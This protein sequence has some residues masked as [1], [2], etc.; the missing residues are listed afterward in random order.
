VLQSA[1]VVLYDRLV[2]AEV[3]AVANP[4]AN[5][6]YTG[7]HEGEQ[8]ATQEWVSN[9]MLEQARSGKTV[10]RLKGGDPFVFGRGGEEALFLS[11][12][13]IDVEVIPGISAALSA[14]AAAGI[15]LTFRG[16]SRSFAVLTGHCRVG[17]HIDWKPYIHVDTLVI[18]MGV[19]WRA[20][21][22]RQLMEAGRPAD[23]PAAFIERA[24]TSAQRTVFTTL[25]DI[26]NGIVE[27]DAP[28]VLVVGAVASPRLRELAARGS[29]IPTSG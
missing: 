19:K 9:Q 17:E 26:A 21:I 15:P 2:T 22:A 16:L 7:K 23:E 3:L 14:P 4:H 29:A 11:R 1:D 27:V 24:T 13:D 12:H 20:L 5:F 28:A 10:V 18:L 8:E 25:R 6:L